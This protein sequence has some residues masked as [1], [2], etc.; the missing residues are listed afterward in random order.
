M[1]KNFFLLFFLINW[2]C[3]AEESFFSTQKGV[4]E[5]YK[6]EQG[7][8]TPFLDELVNTVEARKEHKLALLYM[9]ADRLDLAIEHLHKS[10]SYD[11]HYAPAYLT[12][13]DV[14]L[15]RKEYQLSYKNYLKVLEHKPCDTATLKGLA[16]IAYVWKDQSK[17]EKQALE[18]YHIL[19]QCPPETADYLFYEGQLLA[20]TGKWDEG[21]KVLQRCLAIHPEYFDAAVQIAN[22]YTRQ[23]KW[24]QAEEIYRR[25]PDNTGAREGLIRISLRKGDYRQ[26]EKESLKILASYPD[27]MDVRKDLVVA[28]TSRLN[29]REAKRQYQ[30]L[31]N[32]YPNDEHLWNNQFD[33]KSHTNI[34]VLAEADY[35]DAKEN[36]PSIKQPVVKDYYFN[37]GIIVKIP[38]TNRWRL[39]A[40]GILYHQRE[41]DIYPP[42]GINYNMYLSGA[43]LT[44]H[45]FFYKDWRWDLVAREYEAWGSG[46]M[47]F[48]FQKLSRFEPGTSFVYN[49]DLQLA[50]LGGHYES[51]V[52]KNFAQGIS[53]LLKTSILDGVYGLKPDIYLH[54]K[55]EIGATEVFI[56][57]NIHNRR[58]GQTALLTCGIPFI[59]KYFRG[60]YFFELA[61][62]RKL[63][64]NYFS[65][66]QQTRHTLG[67]RFHIEIIERIDFELQYDHRNQMSHNL[68]QP[69]GDFIYVAGSQFIVANRVGSIL[70]YRFKDKMRFEAAGHYYRD[71]LP[72]RDW[73][74]KGSFLWQ[75]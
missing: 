33:V 39:D 44:S 51:F 21:I 67:L 32:K 11:P 60:L 27:D 63:S 12:L 9:K 70:S 29:Y 15:S 30:I 46:Q 74:L 37:S 2:S 62:F 4:V 48:P 64:P 56:Y 58:H 40:K 23:K 13:G 26:A 45:Y 41:N 68:I 34:G 19:N 65:Y 28:L 59:D 7:K 57:D 20:R 8:I 75:F 3:F 16:E 66:K 24:D 72:Y 6:K 38:V 42:T 50:S 53:Q 36:D 17:T 14:Y 71:T 10:I 69:I 5:F 1:L 61:S 49:S 25:Y 43:Q 54:P 52:I 31:L 55:V 73:N 35:V 47:N 18:I 22:I